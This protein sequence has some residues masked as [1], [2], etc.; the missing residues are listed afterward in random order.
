MIS[1]VLPIKWY[2]C[3]PDVP[4][5]PQAWILA[6]WQ[7]YWKRSPGGRR[8]LMQPSTGYSWKCDSSPQMTKQPQSSSA[9]S[10]SSI[11][12]AG[13]DWQSTGA[14]SGSYAHGSLWPL[15]GCWS[16]Y[17]RHALHTNSSS[18]QW[19]YGHSRSR[20]HGLFWRVRVLGGLRS[21]EELLLTA[22][23]PD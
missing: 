6:S 22:Q 4:I 18:S 13:I 12:R 14:S 11:G 16:S 1:K 15:V 8:T 17:G 9:T 7:S 10:V 19:G 5:H 20:L 3:V 2:Q 23:V 21:F